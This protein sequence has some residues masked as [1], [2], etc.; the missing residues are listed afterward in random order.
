MI[1]GPEYAK[2]RIAEIAAGTPSKAARKRIAE[3][4][5]SSPLAKYDN[6]ARQVWADYLTA[7]CPRAI[8]RN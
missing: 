5:A 8:E 6:A 1:H 4:C 2:A 7:D 3:L